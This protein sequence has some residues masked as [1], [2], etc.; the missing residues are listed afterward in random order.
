[1]VAYCNGTTERSVVAESV[2]EVGC[3]GDISI[4]PKRPPSGFDTRQEH[5]KQSE[6]CTL[7]GPRV[8]CKTCASRRFWI[9]APQRKMKRRT[10]LPCRWGCPRCLL[11]VLLQEIGVVARLYRRTWINVP[12]IV[13][14][15]DRVGG[16]LARPRGQLRIGIAVRRLRQIRWGNEWIWIVLSTLC[17]HVRD[18]AVDTVVCLFH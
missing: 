3:D 11:L 2:R 7:H 1:M 9:V 17:R 8:H 16:S 4:G 5:P 14:R 10:K 13:G 15:S 12:V 18:A 6:V